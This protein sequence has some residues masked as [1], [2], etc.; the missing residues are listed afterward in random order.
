M[1][2]KSNKVIFLEPESEEPLAHEITNLV[3]VS[4]HFLFV[5]VTIVQ[6]AQKL[7]RSLTI[8][9]NPGGRYVETLRELHQVMIQCEKLGIVDDSDARRH[10]LEAQCAVYLEPNEANIHRRDHHLAIV[11]Q[12]Q[13]GLYAT[14]AIEIVLEWIDCILRPQA[15]PVASPDTDEA[16]N[17]QE[18]KRS[19]EEVLKRYDEGS[20]VRTQESS[21]QVATLITELLREKASSESKFILCDLL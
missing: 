10:L 20:L 15:V 18:F 17:F 7:S 5:T 3:D 21:Q 8:Q 11:E 13:Q 12:S 14:G 2:R 9:L 1:F 6:C 16:L 19:F 4:S